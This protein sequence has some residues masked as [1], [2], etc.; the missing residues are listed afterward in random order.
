MAPSV[1]GDAGPQP[2]TPTPPPPHEATPAPSSSASTTATVAANTA[3]S[4]RARAAGARHSLLLHGPVRF[5]DVFWGSAPDDP[6][7]G[8]R[9]LHEV[10]ARHLRELD[11]LVALVRVR[12]SIEEIAASRFADMARLSGTPA[13]DPTSP[14]AV[15]AAALGAGSADSGTATATVSSVAPV[16]SVGIGRKRSFLPTGNG[17]TSVGSSPAPSGFFGGIREL[18]SAIRST[19][20]ELASSTVESMREAGA[21]ISSAARMSLSESATLP[22]PPPPAPSQAAAAVAMA[23]GSTGAEALELDAASLSA[24]GANGRTDDAASLGPATRT[25]REQMMAMAA[26]HRR[27]A[28]ALVLTVLTPLVGFAEQSR[29]GAGKL[30]AE[31]DA[32]ARELARAAA[33]VEAQRHRYHGLA[34]IARDEDAKNRAEAAAR[35]RPPP[36]GPVL[37][38]S[39]AVSAQELHEVVAALRRDVKISAVLTPLGLFEDCFLGD[40]AVAVV[41]ARFPHAPRPDIRAL[42]QELVVRRLITPVVGGPPQPPTSDAT[43]AA[44]TAPASAAPADARFA[45]NLPYTFGA[46]AKLRSGEPP[47]VSARREAE[48]ARIAYVDAVAF[49][50]R[51]RDAVEITVAAFL[52]AA[53]ES[54]ANRLAVAND[55]LAALEAAQ[56]AAVAEVADMWAPRGGNGGDPL[57]A[58]ATDGSDDPNVLRLNFLELP[59]PAAGVQHVARR[60]RT[61]YRHAP[62]FLFEEFG[63]APAPALPFGLGPDDLAGAPDSDTTDDNAIADQVPAPFRVCMAALALALLPAAAA[64][65]A[66]LPAAHAPPEAVLI[67]TEAGD[68]E[69]APTTPP[70]PPPASVA[71]S[72]APAI[73]ESISPS[74]ALAACEAWLLP[75]PDAPAVQRLRR[76]LNRLDGDGSA[77]PQAHPAVAAAVARAF[78][79]EA[80]DSLVPGELYDAFAAIYADEATANLDEEPR[81]ATIAA[82]L[83]RLSR[84]RFET[85]KMLA[86]Y[87]HEVIRHLDSRDASWAA[88]RVFH[89]LAPL[90]LRPRQ[91]T[92]ETLADAHPRLLARD[93]VRAFPTVFSCDAA[94]ALAALAVFATR[95][96]PPM[97]ARRSPAPAR[98]PAGPEDATTAA[99]LAQASSAS[100]ADEIGAQSPP[101]TQLRRNIGSEAFGGGAADAAVPIAVDGDMEEAAAA[102]AAGRTVSVSAAGVGVSGAAAAAAAEALRAWASGGGSGRYEEMGGDGPVRAGDDDDEND[103][104]EEGEASGMKDATISDGAE[105]REGQ[106]PSASAEAA[107]LVEL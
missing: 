14:A 6:T 39:R 60:Y 86:G 21:S 42:C 15:I 41:Q 84:P 18:A 40:D 73:G 22:M 45:G 4:A 13:F 71:A 30:R 53:Q 61:G 98:S 56:M 16:R 93:A 66:A 75:C 94:A 1:A 101:P 35:A 17:V 20:V 8:V 85:L 99:Q 77:A 81:L 69:P 58:M 38:G 43:G 31:V 96:L 27:H 70:S 25:L 65:A 28:D 106:G 19:T 64:A 29:R 95:P 68:A 5:E 104:N 9:V 105:E 67:S 97:P 78:L 33:V 24:I 76:E 37:V 51:A 49:A 3:L 2:P 46:R 47:A 11:D 102:L 52:A 90:L 91:D 80:P 72:S 32:A 50:G 59:R 36:M 12:V 88:D 10:L 87:F 48:T 44:S 83:A 92:R 107:A 79:A 100:Q 7:E 89:A 34:R 103:E 63:R 74:A 62:A 54:A 26:I 82:M 57:P 23:G 55:A